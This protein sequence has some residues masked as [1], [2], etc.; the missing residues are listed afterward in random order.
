[1]SVDKYTKEELKEMSLIDVAY[2]IMNGGKTPYAFNELM[3]EVAKLVGLSEEEVNEKI[4]QFYTDVNI[5]GRFLSLGDNRWG[6]RLWYPVDKSEE[7]V[8]TVTKPKKKKA[9][10][11][12]DDDFDDFDSLEED[13]D[14]FD[15]FD[16]DLDDEELLD[17][18][19][20]LDEEGDDDLLDDDLSEEDEDFDEDLEEEY[21]IEDEEEEED[22]DDEFEDDE[23]EDK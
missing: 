2:E 1:M 15:D 7:D 13:D 18:D 16:A 3:N 8:V 19:D 4:A 22:E 21:E 14:D 5:D 11:A 23:D 9:K 6:L 20:D 17:E 12:V 10:K